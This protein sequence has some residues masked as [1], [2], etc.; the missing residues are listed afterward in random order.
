SPDLD[1]AKQTTDKAAQ[2]RLT[3]FH[4]PWGWNRGDNLQIAFGL[5]ST[6]EHCYL[7]LNYYPVN[8]DSS[9]LTIRLSSQNGAGE[10]T[11]NLERKT[12][13]DTGGLQKAAIDLGKLAAGEYQLTISK[14]QESQARID[15]VGLSRFADAT[16]FD[17]PRLLEI[18]SYEPNRIELS[19]NLTK[20]AFVVLS[21]IYYPGWRATVDGKDVAL[22]RADSVLRAIPVREG[23]HRIEFE[24]KPGSLMWGS[25]ISL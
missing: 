5:P 3:L 2:S 22:V 24:Y 13:S 9:Q 14:T 7:I 6:T 18:T 1:A 23:Q 19:A 21:E 15:S 20:P 12:E 25:L 8:S 11:I 10:T 16:K 4:P 17:N